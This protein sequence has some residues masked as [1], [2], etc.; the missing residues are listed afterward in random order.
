MGRSRP[1]NLLMKRVQNRC[2]STY[3]EIFGRYGNCSR[4]LQRLFH[5]NSIDS[6]LRLELAFCSSCDS[7]VHTPDTQSYLPRLTWY[8]THFLTILSKLPEFYAQ[9]GWKSPDDAHDGPFQFAMGTQSHYFD[10][11]SSEPYYQKAFNT[12]MTAS[13]R[14]KG[15]SWFS[16]FPVEEKLRVED[17]TAP[18]LVDIGG[19]KGEDILAFRDKFPHLPGKIILQDLPVVVEGV[20]DTTPPVEVQGY[21]FFDKQPVKGGKAYYLRTVLHDWPD[22]QALQILARVREAMAPDSLLL[23]NEVLVPETNRSLCSVV[24]D[25][26]MMTSYAAL[27]RTQA[28]FKALLSEAG[29]ELVNI[30]RPEGAKVES[31]QQAVLLEAR[32][33]R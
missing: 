6:S 14:R 8:R 29:F 1:S 2:F 7:W 9:K 21:N 3:H 24:A 26:A 23:I 20:Q 25:L 22:T 27:E 4:G 17:S 15:Q 12:T 33:K 11:L 18:L 31:S 19:G 30:W 5:L 28:Q 13:F 16:F 32:L 10:F